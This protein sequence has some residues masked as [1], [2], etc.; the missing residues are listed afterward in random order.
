LQ[1][2]SPSDNQ[3]QSSKRGDNMKTKKEDIPIISEGDG[4]TMLALNGFGQ[5]SVSYHEFKKGTD[6]TEVLKGLPGDMCPCPHYGYIFEGAFRFIF[7]DGTEEVYKT[8][9]VY[10]APAP[11]N[12]IVDEDTRLLDFSPQ[13][14]HDELMEHLSKVMQQ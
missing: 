2:Y 1:Y 8:G 3:E 13:H 12:A 7:A 10:Y 14:E 4:N 9:D 5:F 6:F 11:H